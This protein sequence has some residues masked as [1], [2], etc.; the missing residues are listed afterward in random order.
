VRSF[1]RTDGRI[2]TQSGMTEGCPGRER[3]LAWPQRAAQDLYL[4]KLERTYRKW[5]CPPV[6]EVVVAD[7]GTSR[8]SAVRFT[9]E[10]TAFRE[11]VTMFAS[12]PTPQA[13]TLFSPSPTS[14]STYAA[15]EASPPAESACSA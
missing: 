4:R 12:M 10:A 14:H 11:A 13:T 7:Q 1:G 6:G 5:S 9:A 8:Q 15:A 2:S 3:I